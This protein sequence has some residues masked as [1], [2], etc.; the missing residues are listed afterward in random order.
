MDECERVTILLAP[1][2][3]DSLRHLVSLGPEVT[4]RTLKNLCE[5]SSSP[6]PVTNSPSSTPSPAKASASE[7]SNGISSPTIPTY[8]RVSLETLTQQLLKFVGQT[9]LGPV[10]SREI[11]I[12]RN[13]P[14]TVT[15]AI[16]LCARS[17]D[18]ARTMEAS[19]QRWLSRASSQSK[20][21]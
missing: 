4:F 3:V 18:T 6:I 8:T 17:L 21:S 10:T 20:S 15:I 5:A 7:E 9:S 2:Q 14:T 11:R 19:L 13:L 1:A 12:S 16:D